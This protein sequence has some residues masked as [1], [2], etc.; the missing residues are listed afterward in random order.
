[1][2]DPNPTQGRPDAGGTFRD[3]GSTPEMVILPG[4]V[5]QMGSEDGDIVTARPRHP[6]TIKP[7]AIGKHLVTFD[8]WDAYQTAAPGAYRPAEN[9]GRGRQPVINVSWNDGRDYAAWLSEATGEA[10]RLPTEAE[11]EY[12]AR[13]GSETAFF[14][15]SSPTR[16][17]D[18]WAAI[19]PT[20]LACTTCTAIS[21]NGR[22]IVG[23]PPM[24]G[25]RPMGA[26]GRRVIAIS[27]SPGAAPGSIARPKP[28]RPT[29]SEGILGSAATVWAC[30]SFAR[31]VRRSD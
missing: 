23:T 5:F 13:A 30:G 6:V 24:R 22:W 3:G 17:R 9:W 21:G 12:A 15:G 25:L 16:A 1:M 2:T 10:Y 7:F 27:A 14:V 4:G 11:W 29:A 8:E 28:G 18:P 26:P 20:P 31:L 19:A